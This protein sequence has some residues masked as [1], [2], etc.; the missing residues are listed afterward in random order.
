MCIVLDI[1]KNSESCSHTFTKEAVEAYLRSKKQSRRP[2]VC[3]IVG[4]IS[5]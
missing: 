1:I 3:P 5:L 2:A 4:K